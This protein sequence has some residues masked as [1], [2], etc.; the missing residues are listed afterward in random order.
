MQNCDNSRAVTN[1]TW[2]HALKLAL[3]GVGREMGTTNE[4]S[5]VMLR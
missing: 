4:S 1:V 5:L 3:S 2:P